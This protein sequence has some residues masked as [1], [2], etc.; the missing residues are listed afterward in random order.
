MRRLIYLLLIVLI[1]FISTLALTFPAKSFY[2]SAPSNFPI[3]KKSQEYR[4]IFVGDTMLDRDVE[5]SVYAN[6]AGDFRYPFFYIADLTASADIAF[7]NLEGNISDKGANQGS[8][9]S[10]RMNPLAIE[11][12][13]YAGFDVLSLANNH[14]LDWGRTALSD[15]ISRLNDAG[16]KTVGAGENEEQANAPA[17]FELSDGTKIAYLAYTDLY[18]K[19]FEAT[20]TSAGISH[21]S[22]DSASKAIQKAKTEMSADLVVVSLHWGYEYE[23]EP[24]Q[25]Q[26]DLAYS[27]IDSGA[28]L[29]IGH[30]PHVVQEVEQY[31]PPFPK[32]GAPKG[33]G[34]SQDD[35]HAG[36]IAYSLGNF[37]FD[38][39]FS[40]ETMASLA[41]EVTIKNKIIS[42]VI[43]IPL[44]ITPT[45]QSSVKKL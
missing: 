2:F 13:T 35:K 7:A 39:F 14:S 28:D 42:K 41:I 26:K 36:Y 44:Q 4:L 30:H 5:G 31:N 10:F 11:G 3:F 43:E 27:L 6:G 12:L 9:Y 15:T 33:Q 17:V 45:Y 38:Q 40:K 32:G 8:I 23:T 22:K 21:Y 34:I 16:I 29:I 25:W 18:P 1:L 20:P 24:R 37:I 19:S